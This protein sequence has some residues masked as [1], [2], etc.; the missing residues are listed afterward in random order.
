M[1]VSFWSGVRR[2]FSA[3]LVSWSGLECGGAFLPLSFGGLDS[4]VAFA[5][6]RGHQKKGETKAAEKHRRTPNQTVA[7]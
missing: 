2:Y 3:A 6:F 7:L 5:C 4:N 1:A